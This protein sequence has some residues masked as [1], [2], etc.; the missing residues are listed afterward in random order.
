MKNEVYVVKLLESSA[1]ARAVAAPVLGDMAQ[2]D[3][4]RALRNPR[5]L[6]PAEST[7]TEGLF[8]ELATRIGREFSPPG[9]PD[10]VTAEHLR[11]LAHPE[12]QRGVAR[13]LGCR[14]EALMSTVFDA[15]RIGQTLEAVSSDA[16]DSADEGLFR[17]LLE[18]LPLIDVLF[19]LSSGNWTHFI[20]QQ[21]WITATAAEKLRTIAGNDQLGQDIPVPRL[22]AYLI[23]RAG[24]QPAHPSETYFDAFALIELR[25]RLALLAEQLRD[26]AL[27]RAELAAQIAPD[28]R[29]VAQLPAWLELYEFGSIA[30][31][32]LALFTGAISFAELLPDLHD[33]PAAVTGD[34]VSSEGLLVRNEATYGKFH[35]RESF[36]VAC[37]VHG[38][39][40]PQVILHCRGLSRSQ[41]A[42][43]KDVV[44]RLTGGDLSP[45]GDS[46][47][48]R[49]L[50][51][52]V[53]VQEG[54][55][56]YLRAALHRYGAE[57]VQCA[58]LTGFQEPVTVPA[59]WHDHLNAKIPYQGLDTAQDAWMPSC[60][61][62]EDDL[63][64][65]V[66][67]SPH[68]EIPV[69]ILM[70]SLDRAP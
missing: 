3:L 11:E 16:V 32:M 19:G 13:A 60:Q 56:G 29:A 38:E 21:G 62:V 46:V 61:E 18:R 10:H 20:E 39:E 28:L 33:P 15:V 49:L 53:P 68:G 70:P 67:D 27:D 66:Q 48:A 1:R 51:T 57:A 5:I 37:V 40:E 64:A 8:E 58:I 12:I 31:G 69:E 22:L 42:Q 6:R 23:E 30:S 50:N 25:R 24:R 36:D 65:S 35:R 54:L 2:V 34:P 43:V 55:A 44:Q 9:P 7:T 45:I 26:E 41:S 4:L 14:P 17:S 63:V 47:G 59:P 52:R